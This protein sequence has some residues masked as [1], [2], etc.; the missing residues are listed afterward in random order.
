MEY[1][2]RTTR[3][4]EI[5]WNFTKSLKYAKINLEEKEGIATHM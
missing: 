2:S 1:E 3:Q 5:L 4:L